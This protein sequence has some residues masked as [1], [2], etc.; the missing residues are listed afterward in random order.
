MEYKKIRLRRFNELTDEEKEEVIE[1]YRSINVSFGWYEHLI[2]DFLS[3]IKEKTGIELK[4]EDV[5]FNLDRRANFGVYSNPVFNAICEKF[6]DEISDIFGSKKIGVFFSE[7]PTMGWNYTDFENFKISFY[8]YVS[9]DREKEIK[10]EIF[11]ILETICKLSQKYFN[12]LNEEYE[13]LISD[14]AVIETIEANEYMFS[15]DLRVY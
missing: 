14:E 13:Y 4:S 10:E 7:F 2:E 15:D 1:M 6:G 3:E 9:E 11:N 12:L 8:N 5:V